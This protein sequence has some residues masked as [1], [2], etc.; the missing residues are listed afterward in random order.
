MEGFSPY[1][2]ANSASSSE[3]AASM[4]RQ[5]N[6]GAPRLGTT[7]APPLDTPGAPQ[8]N[9]TRATENPH[10]TRLRRLNLD[11]QAKPIDPAKVSRVVRKSPVDGLDMQRFFGTYLRPKALIDLPQK[12]CK[13]GLAP[14]PRSTVASDDLGLPHEVVEAILS[15]LPIFNL[16][17]ATGI[18]MTFRTIVQ[19]SPLLQRKLFLRPTQKPTRYVRVEYPDYGDRTIVAEESGAS[20]D[21]HDGGEESREE[22]DGEAYDSD[23]S[24]ED[25]EWQWS[26][27]LAVFYQVQNG[28]TGGV[29]ILADRI[30]HCESGVTLASLSDVPNTEGDVTVRRKPLFW[31]NYLDG[32]LAGEKK[33]TTINRGLERLQNHCDG[34][35][36]RADKIE[37]D[38][39]D[40]VIE[41][42]IVIFREWTT[43]SDECYVRSNDNT[44]SYRECQVTAEEEALHG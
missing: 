28:I 25:Y 11:Q 14:K 30:V 18:N 32:G 24:G 36:C 23:D 34:A 41:F 7:E 27:K 6:T 15:H 13:E 38:R 21:V 22:H 40:T 5:K 26:E 4:P 19:Y 17:T 42:P 35:S 12:I 43:I 20:I 8:P 16:I 10:T 44:V 2:P 9:T 37:L 29:T 3:E 39:I 33:D 31:A 1:S